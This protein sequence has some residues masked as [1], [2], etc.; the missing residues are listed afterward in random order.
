MTR[1]ELSAV[2]ELMNDANCELEGGFTP[3]GGRRK[4]GSVLI[5]GYYLVIPDGI[6]RLRGDYS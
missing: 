3:D 6:F 4:N 1:N 2:G 5:R